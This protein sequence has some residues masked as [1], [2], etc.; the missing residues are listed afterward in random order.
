MPNKA[1]KPIRSFPN[2]ASDSQ[3]DRTEPLKGI[4]KALANPIKNKIIKRKVMKSIF[5]VISLFFLAI[6]H[7]IEGA[8]VA[9]FAAQ[10]AGFVYPTLTRNV[11]KI[12]KFY[13][14][15]DANLD[16]FAPRQYSHRY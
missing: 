12:K 13:G 9:A 7:K 4:G 3:I 16:S 2:P 15:A 10:R 11:V 1:N 6:A 14:A 5:L 8:S